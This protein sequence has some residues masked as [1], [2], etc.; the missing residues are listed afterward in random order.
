MS[1]TRQSPTWS[2]RMTSEFAPGTPVRI[3][4]TVQRRDGSYEQE[5]VGT[6]ERWDELPTGSWY[7]HGKHDKLWLRR[8]ILRKADGEVSYITVDDETRLAKLEPAK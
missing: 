8:L 4:Q 2:E 7:A 1:P 3:T 6:I 5:T